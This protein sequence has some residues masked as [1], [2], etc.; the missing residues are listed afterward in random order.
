MRFKVFLV[1]AIFCLIVSFASA[2]EGNF[3]L[4]EGGTFS[5]GSDSPEA[6]K[7]DEKPPHDVTLNSFY[8]GKYEVTNEEYKL[9]KPDHSGK[10]SDPTF[11]VD[12]VS[13][14]DAVEYCNWLS[15]QEG[16]E[17]C[18]TG[19]KNDIVMDMTKNGYRLPTEA[20]WECA[21][22]GGTDTIYFWGDNKEMAKSYCWFVENADGSA[23]P[24]GEKK[25]NPFGLY[26]MN[27]NVMEWCWDW[28]KE[29][30]Y[31]ESISDNPT[32]PEKGKYRVLRGNYFKD[33][34]REMRV[35]MRGRFAPKTVKNMIGFRLVR[36]P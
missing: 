22:R 14:Y 35:T 13:W 12:S 23:H 1:I 20:E 17:P 10:W 3:V 7:V 29:K 34:G 8:I 6:G 2:E 9:F 27:G 36:T 31:P 4:I 11:P 28:Y 26:D 24:V 19:S 30:Y 21:C 16:L 33:G 5:M 15:E 32:G 25:P 18:Y